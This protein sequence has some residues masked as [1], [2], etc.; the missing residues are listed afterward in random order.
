MSR[1][2]TASLISSISWYKNC[3][4]TQKAKAARDLRNM[5]GRIATPPTPALLLGIKFENAV[6]KATAKKPEEIEGNDHFKWIV[7]ETRGGEF[8]R[9]TTSMLN[10][11]GQD[12]CL[13]GKIDAWFPD[14]IK[15][16]KTTSNYKGE[17]SYK[18]SFQHK[19]YLYNE[20]MQKFR[21]VVGVFDDFQRI[22]DHHAVDVELTDR[23]ALEQDIVNTIKEAVAFLKSNTD[24]YNLYVTTY[25]KY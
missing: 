22:V 25:S 1:L 16:I 18:K 7:D 12:Y 8:Q 14:V 15:D 9:K 4:P 10:I 17:D 19:I 6:V 2:V 11:D 5:L 13:Y 24:L 20:N 3:Y 21:Y 23:L